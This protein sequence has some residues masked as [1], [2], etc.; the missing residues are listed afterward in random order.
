VTD[1]LPEKPLPR[2]SAESL[3]YWEGAKQHRLLIQHCRACGQF[4]FPPS[5]RCHH[6]LSADFAWDE[7][8][9]EG[10]IYSFVVYHR[11]YHPGFE[12]DLP[13]VV[14]IVALREGPRLLTNIVGARWQ[15]V[16]CDLPVNVV[17]ED[18]PRGATIPKFAIA[19]PQ[20]S[21][22]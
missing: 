18:D 16:R 4:W 13:Y 10:R 19:E 9:G 12:R 17:F 22:A 5:A 11:L 15:D 8:S 21:P 3:A 20:S 2:A 1:A 6:C 14:A 7:V